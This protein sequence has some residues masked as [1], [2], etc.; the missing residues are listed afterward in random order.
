MSVSSPDQPRYRLAVPVTTFEDDEWGGFKKPGYVG[1]LPC[2]KLP[3][4]SEIAAALERLGE[5]QTGERPF[6]VGA[7]IIEIGNRIV[8]QKRKRIAPLVG[9]VLHISVNEWA[10]K[11]YYFGI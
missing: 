6:E 10:N 3:E 9:K 1:I 8:R 2:R 11:S 7:E 4:K 5:A